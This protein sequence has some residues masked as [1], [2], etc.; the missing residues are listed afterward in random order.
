MTISVTQ[1]K[2][3]CLQVIRDMERDGHPVDVARRGKIVARIF[4]AAER[5]TIE[6]RPWKRLQGSGRLLA[7]PDESVL[8]EHD[9]EAIG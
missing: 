8:D 4:P 5:Q 1:L 6:K 7:S 9:F 2:A 3:R